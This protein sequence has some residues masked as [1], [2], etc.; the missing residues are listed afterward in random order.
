LSARVLI[1]ARARGDHRHTDRVYHVREWWETFQVQASEL[2]TVPSKNGMRV[3]GVECLA[4]TVVT[5]IACS[6]SV[7]GGKYTRLN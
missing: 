2:S 6:M 1:L 5:M 3:E 4:V 7:S